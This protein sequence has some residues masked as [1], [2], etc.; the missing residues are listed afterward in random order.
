[1]LVKDLMSKYV[2]T[3]SPDENT[4]VA[5]RMLSRHNVGILPVC[6]GDGKLQG[7]VT[8]RDIVLRCIAADK[9][10]D[11]TP[12]KNVMTSRVVT[13][14]PQDDY[15]QASQKMAQEQVRRILVTDQEKVV[16]ILSLGDLTR[17]QD[18]KLEAAEAM[19]EICSNIH[20]K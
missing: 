15:K 6:T 10:P 9:K 7:V 16:G 4:S 3:I 13:V 8:D 19:G 14:S 11:Q 20:K 5:A 2:V 1:M 17:A 12:V 18:L